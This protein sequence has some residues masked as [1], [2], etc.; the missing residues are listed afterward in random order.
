[1]GERFPDSSPPRRCR[2]WGGACEHELFLLHH[3]PE[4]D[5]RPH[6]K[7]RGEVASP[8][9]LFI[10]YGLPGLDESEPDSEE[11]DQTPAVKARKE[12]EEKKELLERYTMPT[13]GVQFEDV[14]ET[15][16][17]R[18]MQGLGATSAD[19]HAAGL[20]NHPEVIAMFASSS[21][22]VGVGSGVD[23]KR[24]RTE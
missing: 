4:V 13:P 8:R 9:D 2:W 23:S 1:L 17:V 6:R 22:G 7:F 11:E 18:A 21:A 20:G 5:S 19:F 16:R 12:K 24:R 10:P 3:E 14:D 15:E